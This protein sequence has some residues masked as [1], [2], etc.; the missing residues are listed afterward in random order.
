MTPIRQRFL[1]EAHA[2]PMT[3]C[4]SPAGSHCWTGRGKVAVH[5]H[6]ARFRL[7]PA[8][9]SRALWRPRP[10]ASR[11]RSGSNCRARPRRAPNRRGT[12]NAIFEYLESSTTAND[13]TAHPDRIRDALRKHPAG[14]TANQA[15]STEPEAHHLRFRPGPV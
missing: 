15:E 6:T 2:C 10:S 7:V 8:L 3:S 1:V 4:A 9:A 11:A 12:A 14:M 5:Y 13:V